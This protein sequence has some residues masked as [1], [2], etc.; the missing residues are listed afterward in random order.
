VLRHPW[1]GSVNECPEA[2][3]YLQQLNRRQEN[4]ARQL[5]SLT[6][7]NLSSIRDR[8]DLRNANDRSGGRDSGGNNGRDGNEGWWPWKN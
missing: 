5:A 4:E 3:T 1:K 7:W 2:Q 6:G 8:M